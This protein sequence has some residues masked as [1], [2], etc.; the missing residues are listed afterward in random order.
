MTRLSKD[1][2]YLKIALQVAQRSTCRR[3]RYGAVIV[4]KDE[5]I[6]STGYPG[7]PR[8]VLHCTDEQVGK[9]FRQEHKI[10]SLQNYDL[11]RSV[12]TEMNAIMNAS[13]ADREGGTMYIAGQDLEKEGTPLMKAQ[14][15]EFCRRIIINSCVARVVILNA[16]GSMTSEYVNDW[17]R[18][19][20]RDPFKHI[21]RILQSQNK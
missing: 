9:C 5:R 8:G 14:P 19:M 7:A 13:P 18:D 3:R 17:V 21:N 1:E 16:D 15:C 10:P 2:Y 4:S 6:V 20:N 12:H 11:C